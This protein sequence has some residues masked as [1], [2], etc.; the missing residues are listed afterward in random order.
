[1][2]DATHAAIIDSLE[3]EPWDGDFRTH[4]V[5]LGPGERGWNPDPSPEAGGYWG[6]AR[7]AYTEARSG[8]ITAARLG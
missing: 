7:I 5:V 4:T 6:P 8:R 1:M 2:S 3:H